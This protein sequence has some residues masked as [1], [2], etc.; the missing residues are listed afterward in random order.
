[1]SLPCPPALAALLARRKV[2]IAANKYVP[3]AVAAAAQA[4]WD[5]VV[6]ESA[7]LNV[8]VVVDASTRRSAAAA[9][10]AVLIAYGAQQLVAQQHT[11][12]ATILEA[13][14]PA[15][16]PA[17][18]RPRGGKT[19]PSVPGLAEGDVLYQ[20]SIPVP[21]RGGKRAAS[22]SSNEGERKRRSKRPMGE[23]LGRAELDAS[24]D[25]CRRMVVQDVSSLLQD[26]WAAADE[27]HDR[28]IAALGLVRDDIVRDVVRRVTADL[29]DI[30]KKATRAS[31]KKK[32]V[33]AKQE[34]AGADADADADADT[35]AEGE[36]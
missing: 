3:P 28:M 4:D 23:G 24:L 8:D 35:D 7:G 15:A 20:F 36:R 16:V 31:L 13:P 6:A 12:C 10:N 2:L 11:G 5:S 32:S 9:A 29:G 14:V 1:M 25:R 27:R 18:A 33:V 19:A 30:V 22:P 26:A 34:E 17:P 21:F